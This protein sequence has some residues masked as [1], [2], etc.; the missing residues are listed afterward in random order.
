MIY[1]SKDTMR[2]DQGRAD[3]P[4]KL[5][6][7]DVEGV[8]IPKRRFLLFE[9]SRGHVPTS[10]IK[11]ATIG[12]LYS[13]GA[14]S[15]ESSLRAVF[16]SLKGAQMGELLTVFKGLPLMPGSEKL[17][18]ELKSLGFKTALISSG[19]PDAM[20]ADLAW[21][22]G[23]DYSK[24]IHVETRD[25][26]LTGE[27]SGNVIKEK[28]K[29]AALEEIIA[30]EGLSSENCAIVADDLNN[31]QLLRICGLSIGFNPDYV[32]GRR[33]DYVVKEDLS[34][35]PRILTGGV[36]LDNRVSTGNVIREAIHTSG[37][38]I[39]FICIYLL[40]NLTVATLLITAALIYS[41]SELL[42]IHGTNVP[43]ISKITLWAADRSELQEFNTAPIF[44]ALGIALTL[45]IFP[46]RIGYAAI[47]VLT[48]GDSS[49]SI[50][51]KRFGKTK[52]PFNRGK[53]VEGSMIGL[54]FA[55]LG[56]LLFV[57]PVTAI[58]GAAAGLL[59]EALPLPLDDNL[60]IPLAAGASMYLI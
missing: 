42:R 18:N 3:L 16:R 12:G 5:V 10:F 17:F 34:E 29:V 39:P 32:I 46:T 51:G 6:V 13:I 56:S 4:I 53:S 31:M 25:G 15:L 35:I 22:L 2:P 45:L 59:I 47:A 58:V 30:S 55:F 60:L 23:A 43:V 8:L 20:V 21:R 28:G 9:A 27:I 52:I 33:A 7:F 44:H 40:N 48:L 41:A 57:D 54:V 38:L 26:V 49:A 1:A 50:L 19:L 11:F 24:G 36:M 14:L 37:L